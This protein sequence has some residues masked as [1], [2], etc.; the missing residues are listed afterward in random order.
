M[1]AQRYDV[2]CK[3]VDNYGDAGVSWRLARQL[4]REHDL[5]VTLWIDALASLAKIAPRVDA[6]RD[7][8]VLAGVRIRVWKEPFAEVELPN[9][10]VE[11]FG[12]ELPQAYLDAMAAASRPPVWINLEYLSAEPWVESA[13]GLPSPQ[14]RL[15]LTRYFFF[16][17]FT[18]R[19]GGLL[20]EAGLIEAYEH[21]RSQP[22]ARDVL[23]KALGIADPSDGI[24]VSLF[25]YANHGLT[26]LF[27]AWAESD[28]PILCIVPEGVATAAL[29]AWTGGNVPHAK[30]SLTRG[31]LTLATIPFLAQDEYDRLLWHCDVNVV[32]GEDSFVRAQWTTRPFVWHIYPQADDAHRVKI[33]EFLRRYEVGLD[34]EVAQR[35]SRFWLAFN[36]DQSDAAALAWPAFRA[37]LPQ[38]SAHG[39]E[40][41]N[42]L[43]K[44]PDL[45]SE[46]V[47]FCN[48]RL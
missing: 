15:P 2:F 39:I 47:D 37:V 4:V 6:L 22:A 3:V 27:D 48:D 24:A 11:A 43:R 13:H 29:D 14:P 1:P 45:A 32:R 25:C 42:R 44:L 12:C 41:V 7:D 36:D 38:V 5:A 26:S 17:G 31:R 9:V 16:P 20:R 23:W 35:A 8:Q 28:E 10:V 33:E 40:W 30:Q 18:P 19:T 34:E 21:A 46:L